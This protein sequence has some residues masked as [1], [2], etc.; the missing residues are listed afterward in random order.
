MRMR[1]TRR[2]ER[3]AAVYLALAVAVCTAPEAR[4]QD[5]HEH[6]VTEMLPLEPGLGRDSLERLAYLAIQNRE[7]IRA[8][9]LASTLLKI[10]P[11]SAPAHCVLGVVMHRSEGSLPRALFHLERSRALFEAR[12]G[13]IA[14]DPAPWRWHLFAIDEAAHVNG[15]MGNDERKLELLE[16]VNELYGPR[17]ASARGGLQE[18]R[19]AERGWPLMRLHRYGEARA[20]VN[21]ALK[22][23]RY[24]ALEQHVTAQNALCAIE[25]EQQHRQETYLECMRS[26]ELDR[27]ESLGDPVAYTNAAIGAQAVLKMDEAEDLMI[28]GTRHFAHAVVSNP[29]L[30]LMVLYVAQG[31]IPEALGAMRRM[32]EWRNRQPPYMD[33]QNRA[34]TEVAAAQF[35]I[36]AGRPF[37]AVHITQRSLEQPDRTGY[38]SSDT[39]Q[40]QSAAALVH[41]VAARTAAELKHEE[42]SWLPWWPGMLARFEAWGLELQ[43]W[44][45]GRRAAALLA[46]Q[47]ILVS[48]VRPYLPGGVEIAEWVQLELPSLL[49]PGVLSAA[50]REA[51]RIESLEDARGYFSAFEAEIARLS[52]SD[53]ETLEKS[54]LALRELPGSEVLI[55]A[56]VSAIG[57]EA[58]WRTGDRERAEA[59]FGRTLEVDPGALRRL[60]VRLPVRI[61]AGS[62]DLEQQAARALERSPRL[63][64]GGRFVVAVSSGEKELGACLNGP[65]GEVLGCA[66]VTPR[67]GESSDELAGRLSG[68]FHAEV[69]APRIDLTQADIRSLDG[70]PT[71][72]G[73][74]ATEHLHTILDSITGP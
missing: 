52:G 21:D 16:V 59:L 7:Y 11:D 55:Q 34:Q 3:G 4:A 65:R 67:A 26:A 15:A 13:R 46:R 68:E 63:A 24:R 17:L 8:R 37:E 49:G 29:W 47:R 18:I 42:A 27:S 73:G 61:T 6:L 71:A 31:R 51:R 69:F 58:A 25:G 70:S 38:T 45:A 62:G 66:R 20:A 43:A 30:D 74:R 44:S 53:R 50:V 40:W 14:L 28:E 9:E 1:A 41:T 35:L 54:E 2:V 72:A 10:N 5:D 64:K 36:V 39:E 33:E 32:Q 23:D 19:I 12:Y 60:A 57:A 22:L 56:R 48:T